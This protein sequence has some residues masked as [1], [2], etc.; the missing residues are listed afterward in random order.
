[1]LICP[2]C[3]KSSKETRFMEAFCV[4]CYPYNLKT[5]EKIEIEI[6]K[7]CGKMRLKGEWVEYNSK[8]LEEYIAGKCKGEF[9]SVEYNADNETAVFT[10]RKGDSEARV[11][12]NIP[13]KKQIVICPTCSKIA[14]GYFEAIIQLRGNENEIKKYKNILSRMLGRRTFISKIDE[15]KEGTD[16]FVGS[17]RVV[18]ETIAE[19]GLKR[20]ITRKLSGAKQGK[21]FYRTTFLL[22]FE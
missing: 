5:P 3:G 1:M 13:F 12:R 15:K 11:E 2:K 19:L 10:V 7:R 6:C 4:E 20:K 9:E 8:K 21:R 14:G 18:L 17:T 16:L 22:R